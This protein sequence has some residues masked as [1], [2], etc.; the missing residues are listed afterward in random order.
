MDTGGTFTDCV[1]IDPKGRVRTAKV[2]SSS[3]LR[4]V[5]LSTDGTVVHL[6]AAWDLPDG[7]LEGFT[8]RLIGVDKTWRVA[9]STRS[10]RSIT[11]EDDPGFPTP[12]PAGPD[13]IEPDSNEL[14][15]IRPASDVPGPINPDAVQPGATVELV[16]PE[17]APVLA[18]RAVTDTPRHSPL[19]GLEMRL[20]TTRG[21][22]AL[23]E[24][25]GARTALLVTRGFAD[26]LAIGTQQRPELF[27]REI[28]RPTPLA[29]TVV[30][31]DERVDARG[32]VLGALEAAGLK[33]RLRVLREEGHEAVAIAL[34]HAYLNPVHEM[35]LE[36]IARAAGFDHVSRS[37]EVAPLQGALSRAETTVVDA[38]LS[39]VLGRYLRD[40]CAVLDGRRVRVMTSAGGLAGAGVF[41]PRDSLLSGPAGGVVG[42]AAIG[43]GLGL[44]PLLSFDM[45]GTST[46]VAR[47]DGHFD[48]VFE[49]VVGDAHLAAPA[50][51][52]ETVAAGG[53]SICRATQGLLTVGPDSA[54]AFPGSAC[55]GAGGPLTLTDVNLLLG[56]IVAERMP[57]PIDRAAAEARLEELRAD[58]RAQTGTAPAAEDI[59]HGLLRI[60]DERMAEAIRRVSLRKGHDP[61]GH[62]L[63]VFGGAGAQHA[64]AVAEELGIDRVVVPARAGLLSAYGLAHAVME[65]FAHEQVLRPADEDPASVE[66]AIGRLAEKARAG[67]REDGIDP[68]GARVTR[69]IAEVRY[70]GQDSTLLIDIEDVGN[71]RAD[72]ER[73]YESLFAHRPVQRTVEL[74][75][76]RVVVAARGDAHAIPGPECPDAGKTTEGPALIPDE[77]TVTY[78]AKGWSAERHPSGHLLLRRDAGGAPAAA[79]DL[80]MPGRKIRSGMADDARLTSPGPVG[81]P[82]E[83]PRPAAVE[84]ELFRHRF[85]SMALEMGER[86]RQTSVST[87][88]KERLDFSCAILDTEGR[89]VVNAP[90][91]PV[92]LGALGLCV[93]RLRE[94]M[95]M[96]P[97]DVVVTNHPAFGGSHLPDVTV[98]SAV[99][100]EGGGHVGHVAARAHHAEIGGMSPGSMPAGATRLIQEGVV[101]PPMYI[102]RGGA[103]AWEEIEG[104]LR[105]SPYPTRAMADN[106]ADL[107]AM[108]AACRRGAVQLADLA[109]GASTERVRAQMDA[110]RALATRHV[111][112]ALAKLG[113][114][115]YSAREEMDDGSPVAVKLT[116]AGDRA[117]VDFTGSAPVHPGNLNATD[118]IVHSAVL[119]ALRLLVDEPLP[120]NEGLLEAI[121]LVIERGMLNPEFSEKAEECPAIVGGNVETSQRIVDVLLKATGIGAGGQ[122]TMNNLSFGDARFGFYET[123]GG[124]TGAGPG[125]DG[126]H[127]VHS[128]MTNTRLTDAEV[129]EHRYP[130]RV[131]RIE[132][133]RGSGGRGRWTGGNGMIRELE[134]LA[135][136]ELSLMTQ[137]RT[138]G[139]YGLEGGG[140]GKAGRQWIVRADGSRVRLGSTARADLGAGDRIVIE[141]PG[142]GG[143]GREG[144]RS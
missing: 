43:E 91:I 96:G 116:I 29:E 98:V 140:R 114:G 95:E 137:R 79:E 19:P 82:G 143:Y 106:L 33:D 77:D 121:D 103:P 55:Y 71:L 10:P 57:I 1:A 104:L 70:E 46:D 54:G 63:V 50:L 47:W 78:V 64:C 141:T 93:R 27:A 124:G 94:S 32:E 28:R 84:L 123:L 37:S 51:A 58:L 4:A 126:A 76:L 11:L 53:G 129:I 99:F 122:G 111:R 14:D 117:T 142:G 131:R 65:R 12:G 83:P 21:T 115:E 49:L 110:L 24:R 102:V 18:A 35:A 87:N 138:V 107:R 73:E 26:L 109:R 80:A 41:R 13:H 61:A 133:R 5:V 85:E 67:L 86:L 75:S 25:R 119:Y 56:R 38:T 105:D 113:A 7:F 92:H 134:F 101:I 30:E 120:L 74:V 9:R 68:R 39:P 23:L 15:A 59:L 135:P 60:A 144:R 100:D 3:A 48:Y 52:I 20:A 130:V 8:L 125:F 108:V 66:A 44:R 90:H 72:F 16:S 34:L 36:E 31:I 22:N 62:A 81:H 69:R 128:H 97:G 88:I 127:A 6:E 2:L 17:E 132:I 118:A 139:P 40:V 42:V 136:V 89:L 112:A 45:G